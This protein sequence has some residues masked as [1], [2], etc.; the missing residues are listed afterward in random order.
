MRPGG[1]DRN[2]YIAFES[3]LASIG[4]KS[5]LVIADEG[6]HRR[7]LLERSGSEF[8][9]TYGQRYG[10]TESEVV[11]YYID[12]QKRFKALAEESP[13]NSLMIDTSS[14]DPVER[15]LNFWDS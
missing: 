5:V 11:G 13:I 6:R 9:S 1:I 7:Q 12:E 14:P 4:A 15:A 3:D 2:W 8:F 10:S